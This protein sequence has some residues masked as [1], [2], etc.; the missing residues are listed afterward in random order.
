M[1]VLKTNIM[2]PNLNDICTDMENLSSA[3]INKCTFEEGCEWEGVARIIGCL[4]GAISKIRDDLLREEGKLFK[5]VAKEI[6]GSEILTQEMIDTVMS[7]LK[8]REES[9][10]EYTKRQIDSAKKLYEEKERK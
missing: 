3:T 2:D 9:T 1:D 7:I 10:Y 5:K 8:D 4:W 6:Y